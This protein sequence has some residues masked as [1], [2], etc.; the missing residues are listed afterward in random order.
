MRLVSWNIRGGKHSGV[1][2][3]VRDLG[4]D[5]AV[6]VDCHGKHADRVVA[7]A[8]SAGYPHQVRT[9]AGYTGIVMVSRQPLTQGEMKDEGAPQRWLHARSDYFDLEIAAVYGPLPKTIGLEPSMKEFWSRLV[10]ACDGMVDRKAVLCGDFNTGVDEEDGPPKY[11]FRGA[12]P[13]SDL[14]AHGWRDAY[15]ELHLKGGQ[16][17]WYGERGFRIDHCMLSRSQPT[18]IRAEYVK[19]EADAGAELSR[20]AGVKLPAFPDHAA[21]VVDFQEDMSRPPS[22]TNRGPG[23]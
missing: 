15:R 17:W 11:R 18:P 23:S 7:E 19:L 16:S 1:V 3:S 4:P 13:F 21:L 22:G 8:A 12:K 9:P 5:V 6:L 14:E 2:K 10:P 20:S